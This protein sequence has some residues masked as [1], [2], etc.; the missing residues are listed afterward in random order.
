MD[1]NGRLANIP[2]QLALVSLTVAPAP[3]RGC[4][5]GRFP[6][7][8]RAVDSPWL[9]G[10]SIPAL[11]VQSTMPRTCLAL[12]RQPLGFVEAI[13]EVGSFRSVA[14]RRAGEVAALIAP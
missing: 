5:G 10:R 3:C 2:I 11:L 12:L 9:P 8:A 14:R 13:S 1:G 7:A 4:P 6:V